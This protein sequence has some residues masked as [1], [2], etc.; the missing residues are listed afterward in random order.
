MSVKGVQTL[1][2]ALDIIEL[3]ALQPDGLGVTEIAQR[4]ELNKSTAHRLLSALLERSYVERNG[5]RGAYRLGLK[6]I[7][8][9]SIRLNHLELKTEAQPYLRKLSESTGMS[10]HLGI[11]SGGDVVY[12]EKIE[13]R[14]SIR[15]YS[16]IGKRVPVHCTALGKALVSELPRP[17][18]ERIAEAMA[19]KRFTAKTAVGLEDLAAAAGECR[20][21]GYAIDDEEHEAGI[22]CVGA[23][24]RDYTGRVI[25]AVSVTGEIRSS[26]AERDAGLPR[27]VMEA[28]ASIS[29]R[30]GCFGG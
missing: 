28:A 16:Q 8:V 7:E 27:L 14:Q 30:L 11:L 25:A 2:R 10:V 20:E 21:R 17:E 26:G 23:P 4:L 24:I 13:P 19:F 29:R 1:E 9:G 22:R 3:L 18:L 12:I 15:M 6:V 5:A